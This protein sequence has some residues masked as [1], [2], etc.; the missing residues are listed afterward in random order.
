MKQVLASGYKT[1]CL[2]KN[3]SICRKFRL[4][5]PIQGPSPEDL[6]G[7]SIIKPLVG[8]D[9]HLYANLESFFKLKYPNVS[10]ASESLSI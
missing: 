8:V 6:P 10:I 3:H 1:L 2:N 4:H 9:P 7:V 5:R